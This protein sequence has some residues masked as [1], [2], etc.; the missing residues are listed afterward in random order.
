M[1]K[2]IEI[3]ADSFHEGNWCCDCIS[4][5]AKKS[6][7]TV[8][9]SYARGFQPQY[10]IKN[11]SNILELTVYGSYRS[12]SPLPK[13]IEELIDWGKPDFIAFDATENK[14]LFAVDRKSV[15]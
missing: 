14:I 12:W 15:V 7:Y 13:K 11:D 8:Q 10:I 6:G 2:S 1:K 4:D 3:W 9:K 5:I